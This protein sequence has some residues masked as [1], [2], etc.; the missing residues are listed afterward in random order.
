M[1]T[2][3]NGRR[4]APPQPLSLMAA[5]LKRRRAPMTIDRRALTESD[6]VTS[7]R[8]QEQSAR[9]RTASGIHGEL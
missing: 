8:L 7:N 5:F 9:H 3:D 4:L 2:G 1:R 6:A